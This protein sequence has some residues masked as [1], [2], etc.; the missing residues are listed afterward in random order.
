M[1]EPRALPKGPK[2]TSSAKHGLAILFVYLSSVEIQPCLF[3]QVNQLTRLGLNLRERLVK[4]NIPKC[5]FQLGTRMIDD[6][7]WYFGVERFETTPCCR[8][9]IPRRTPTAHIRTDQPPTVP[10]NLSL[11]LDL[12]GLIMSHPTIF[13][14]R[15]IGGSL[16]FLRPCVSCRCPACVWDALAPGL[17]EPLS[18]NLKNRLVLIVWSCVFQLASVRMNQLIRAVCPALP[19]STYSALT[20]L[21]MLL[22]L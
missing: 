20:N 11:V 9:Q 22:M 2:H 18:G 7:P 21:I 6:E 16:P 3:S 12:V 17:Y 10:Q 4:R 14:K 15:Y 5:V 1:F 19:G 13:I 8:R